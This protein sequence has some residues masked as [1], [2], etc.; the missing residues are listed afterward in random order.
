[1]SDGR[2]DLDSIAWDW[3][4]G[5]QDIAPSGRSIES[6]SFTDRE[7]AERSVADNLAGNAALVRSWLATARPTLGVTW[8]HGAA[9]GR[10]VPKWAE[11]AADI[12]DVT[13]SLALLRRDPSMPEGF[14][15][16][17][18]YP[19]PSRRF[20]GA[21]PT[22][23]EWQALAGLFTGYL[24]QDVG[25]DHG[26]VE[27]GL[28]A[29]A[30]EWPHDDVWAATGQAQHLLERFGSEDA[31]RAAA[32]SLGLEYHPPSTGQSYRRWLGDVQQIL[33]RAT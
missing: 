9:T 29:F 31:T 13:S 23:A 27:G 7:V 4:P 17:T 10:H 26:S 21:D 16:H 11:T 1:M 30:R 20:E 15:V 14:H 33:W 18:A 8:E 3:R 6:S 5:A 24:H 2:I 19:V 28:E 32:E 22:A 25:D 12:V